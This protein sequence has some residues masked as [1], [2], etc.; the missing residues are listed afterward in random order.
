M[1]APRF[2][3][4]TWIRLLLAT[5][6]LGAV[7]F[8]ARAKLSERISTDVLDLIPAG[9][10]A[11]EL[12][13]MRA[14]ASDSTARVALFVLDAPGADEAT[15]TKLGKAFTGALDRSGAFAQ[16]VPF[17]DPA[18]R[19][20][21]GHQLFAQRF[22]LLLATW[23]AA[24]EREYT[25]ARPAQDWPTW[26]AEH[27]A[28]RLE[29]YLAKPEALGF[30]GLLDSDPL[31]LVPE[32]AT[33]FAN[34][35]VL[36]GAS[37]DHVLIW[38]QTR[39]SPLSV[40][41]QQP[42]FA[43]VNEALAAAKAI[44]PGVQL[45][46]HAI[47]RFA[48]ASRQQI[49]RE[50]SILNTL[51]LVAVLIVAVFGLRRI[52]CV[53]HL[54]PVI[55]GGLLGAWVV[56]IATF[57]R[58]HVLVFVVGS[59]LAGVAVDYGFYLYV[60]PPLSANEPY[61]AKVRR[62]L[63]PLLASA[64]TTIIGFLILLFSELPLIR[65]I[66]VFVSAGLLFALATALLWFGQVRRPY[67][68]TRALARLQLQPTP[69]IRR[70]IRIGFLVAGLIALTGPWRLHWR[71]DARD[72]E[73]PAQ[74]LRA[75]SQW[76]QA[77][78]GDQPDRTTFITS[79][80]T[81]TEARHALTAFAAWQHE[82]YPDAGVVSLASVLPTPEDYTAMPARLE[83]LA[84]FPARLRTAL[85]QHGFDP[86]AFQPFF[87]GWT[88]Q[89][90]APARRYDDVVAE[91][92]A[93]L[94]GPTSML[95]SVTPGHCWIASIARQ[96]ITE[97]PPLATSTLSVRKLEHLNRLF[98]RY[99]LSALRLSLIGLGILGLSVFALY[100]LRQG[101]RVFAVP[102][103]ACLFAFGLLGLAGQTLN[104]FHLLG[105]FLGVCLSHNYAIFSIENALRREAPPP[106]IRLSGLT[107]AASFGV[108]ALSHIPVVAA[109][110][111]TVTLIVLA[112]LLI[113]E[114]EPLARIPRSVPV[115]P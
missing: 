98:G 57:E 101:V 7:A 60:Q 9:E 92:D 35:D 113:V 85:E 99:R 77:A 87:T 106:S 84:D 90:Q 22:Q 21:L 41:G 70:L 102:L 4:R 67:A 55:G 16:V 39:G 54:A 26:L 88:A 71:D 3:S 114:L 91:F 112:A 111:T 66:G 95:L 89:R 78:F 61:S 105:A 8:L 10:R 47:G 33:S 38:A 58:T 74:A 103:G 93:A 45:R 25:A 14:L 68:E 19:E 51:S 46:W 34:T 109:L 75:E 36:T 53:A 76:V 5:A 24:R 40:E 56:T 27:T 23:L 6:A 52:F 32:L 94:R 30:Q 79:G 31:L 59:L 73:I 50:V 42:V 37:N 82:H 97:D 18:G 12:L 15:R 1:P 48:A 115:P 20:T 11:P 69:G 83:T 44:A 110:G 28:T 86:A 108:L 65:Q 29:A 17:S 64:L 49:E 81:I 63:K 104:L 80:R 2:S 107:T 43:A 62:L 13:A 96:A 72:L 100:G